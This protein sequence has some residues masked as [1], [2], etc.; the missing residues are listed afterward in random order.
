MTKTELKRK[1]SFILQ[2]SELNHPICCED[3]DFLLSV[4]KNHPDWEI[5]RGVGGKDIVIK[6]T[7][8]G[9]RGFYIIRIDGSIT[10]ISYPT[11]ISGRPSK[12]SEVKSA[13]RSAIMHIVLEF[14]KINTPE[15]CPFT[16]EILNKDN[17]HV[18]HFDLTF[19]ELF[20][21]W[22]SDKEINFLHSNILKHKDGDTQ[23]KFGNVDIIQSFIKFHNQN[24]HLRVVSKTANL[25]I[26]K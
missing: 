16:T 19:S 2:N 22:V 1:C 13:C 4:F 20:N 7:Q 10:D 8:W 6:N 26:L 14:K 18:D 24:T 5:K 25:S 15:K 11:A 17:T 9:N 12:L 21:I 3:R 23:I